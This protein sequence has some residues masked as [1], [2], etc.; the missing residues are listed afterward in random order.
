[1]S[2]NLQGKIEPFNPQK[3]KFEVWLSMLKAQFAYTGIT[4][5][6][7]KKNCLLVSL[8]ADIYSTLASLCA[9]SLPH[10]KTF[11]V[12]VTVL[13][14]HYVVKPSYHRC[15]I[16]F[17]QR[18]KKGEETLRELYADLKELANDCDFGTQFDARVRD[19][20][21][22][23]VD[24]EIYYPHLVAEN[25]SLQSMSS[26]DTLERISNFEKAFCGE[27]LASGVHALSLREGGDSFRQG[28]SCKHCGYPHPS[29]KCKFS[30]LSCSRCGIKGHLKRV[31]RF[32]KENNPGKKGWSEQG[33]QR[34][35][36]SG[37]GF[38]K[39]K[40]NR[41]SANALMEELSGG[42][43]SD[44][45]QLLSLQEVN[46]DREE[47]TDQLGPCVNALATVKTK[48][49][50]VVDGRKIPFEVD[51]GAGV[52]TLTCD[53]VQS[54]NLPV[55]SC[56]KK[57]KAYGN[58]MV[59]VIGKVYVN[60]EYNKFSTRQVFYVVESEP[61]LC[62]RDLMS[63]IG[64]TLSGINE[65]VSGCINTIMNAEE[66]LEGFS[67]DPKLPINSTVAKVHLKEGAVPRF[68][69]ARTVPFHYREMVE[70]ALDQL[71][72]GGIIEPV[73]FS[74][75]A[76][77][78]VPVLKA[79]KRSMRICADFKDLNQKIVCDKYP[80]PR[81]D[82]ILSAVGG[83]KI[84]SKIDLKDA[85]LQ[86]PVDDES[87]KL[88]VINT[89]KGLFKYKR[90]PFGLSSSP[91]IFQKF[92]SQML[93]DIEGV[94]VFLD[95]ILVGGGS[96]EEHDQ[97]LN[98]VLNE[99]KKHN[100]A[101]NKKKTVLNSSSIEY[102]GYV[103]SGNGI[104][105][106]PKKLAAVLEAPP[107][108]SVG[109]VKSFLGMVTYYSRFV[110]NFSSLLSPLY[111]LLKK[112]AVFKWTSVESQAFSKIK[113]E[114]SES[115]LL[116]NFEGNHPVIVETDASPVGVGCVLLQEVNG[117]ERPVYF[118]SKKLSAA[119]LNYSQLDK[120]ALGL[121]FAV[122]KFKYFLLGRKFV[123]RTDHKPLL[124]LFGR[125]KQIPANANARVQRWA[126]LLS[127]YNYDL[128]FKAGK[129]NVVA[130]SLSR[131]P[132]PDSGLDSTTPSEYIHVVETLNTQSFSFN[133]AK[134]MTKNDLVLSKVFQ[135]VKFG[136]VSDPLL[137]E[138]ATVKSDLSIYDGVVLYRNRVVIPTQMRSALLA[139]LHAGHNGINAMKAEAR[140]WIWWPNLDQDI[141]ETIKSCEICFKNFQNPPAEVLSWPETGSPW[142]RLH[143]DYAGPIGDYY[144]LLIVDS[145]TKFLD[146]H[147]TK[148]TTSAVTIAKLRLTFCN[149]GLPDIIV[150][151][152]ASCFVSKEMEFFLRKNGIRH[153]T[154]APYNPSSNGLAERAVKTFKEG[155]RKF[156]DGDMMT[157][158]CR[159]LYNY[160]RTVHSSTGRTP[161]D[162]MFNRNFRGTVEKIKP[163]GKRERELQK[164]CSTVIADYNIDDAVFVR[165]YG[166]G[167]SWLEG[168][169]LEVLGVRNYKVQLKNFGN[170]IWRRHSDQLM[171][172][173]THA[174]QDEGKL[175][176]KNQGLNS[177][178]HPV[179][180]SSFPCSRLPD[181]ICKE[182]KGPVEN[183]LSNSEVS[184][185]P[186]AQSEASGPG[187]FTPPLGTIPVPVQVRKSSRTVKPPDRLNL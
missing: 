94:A 112:G 134:E 49:S 138:Y 110:K 122:S 69:K 99:F 114:L 133:D 150:S 77:P 50:I 1:M 33:N 105:P 30:H 174:S 62:G 173:F 21:F 143:I 64:I 25:L 22:M 40:T 8:G 140:N 104:K 66:Q 119:E 3:I 155:L 63:K 132:V 139:Q 18:K 82:E 102:L 53:W 145:H 164:N 10:E 151:D 70:E 91:A 182:P 6:D 75:W 106:S 158:V 60:V 37:N 111:E 23:A 88:L 35:G 83:S 167:K 54:L 89:H 29:E 160:R 26:S 5:D 56:G 127:Q 59:T 71:V 129:D 116:A 126:L 163:Q 181:P 20:L 137:S 28:M 118:A 165:N 156:T 95:D 144:F 76:A 147:V 36:D 46:H 136:W 13:R 57:L 125:T 117:R 79:D 154:P 176:I 48:I 17:Q 120:E 186:E 19:Q 43:D 101:I 15:L 187:D 179:L 100:V 97:R 55:Q 11:D 86:L 162:M 149:F 121:V 98:R 128:V 31:C 78:I 148:S 107:P 113:T 85:Y 159:F 175:P 52:S 177:S 74:E 7:K 9:P 61:N 115:E 166:Q 185:M 92:M 96:Q 24:S 42:E 103:I 108:K 73:D 84:F 47:G 16:K 39:K 183:T 131:L 123:L 161:A 130:D 67:A 171:P 81:V 87:Q 172:R 4:E 41:K 68:Q 157:R 2:T 80:L 38:Y 152:N 168:K 34:K 146:V 51:S 178:G 142:C 109:D 45:S 44:S 90:L 12:L 27:K 153:I 141:T 93:A 184:R 72:S 135:N 169:I 14:G 180:P 124:G 65:D 170:I 58:G 32:N